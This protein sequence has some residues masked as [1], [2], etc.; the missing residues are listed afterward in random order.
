MSIFSAFPSPAKTSDTGAYRLSVV[1][2]NVTDGDEVSMDG[3]V[4]TDDD[5]NVVAW[6]N[7]P[8]GGGS[9]EVSAGT[10]DADLTVN[11]DTGAAADVTVFALVE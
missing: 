3:A 6:A 9:A 10:D 1:T 11:Q 4:A 7:V 2:A 8:G 5:G